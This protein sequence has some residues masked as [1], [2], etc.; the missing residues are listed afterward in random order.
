MEGEVDSTGRGTETEGV[1]EMERESGRG[2][3]GEREIVRRRGIWR[4]RE[5][6]E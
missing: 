2:G 5:E 1:G 3:E 4:D 6:S